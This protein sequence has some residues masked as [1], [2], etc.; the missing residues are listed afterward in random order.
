ME[1]GIRGASNVL[2]S[3]YGNK[4]P[5]LFL[6]E[7]TFTDINLEG[8]FVP[9]KG[10]QQGMNLIA[11]NENAEATFRI[12]TPI[13]SMEFLEITA[14]S[15]LVTKETFIHE[16]QVLQLD[17]DNK[18]KLK[19]SPSNKRPIFVFELNVSGR[20]IT[21]KITEK[22]YVIDGDE[23][24]VTTSLT[25]DWI[26]VY[27]YHKTS[28]QIVEIGKFVNMGYLSLLGET[29]IYNQDSGNTE[30]LKFDFPKIEIRQQFNLQMLNATN[31]DQFFFMDCV[32]LIENPEDK[33]LLR[34]M[35][36]NS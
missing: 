15:E 27:Y 18:A 20:Q 3:K 4:E 31:P 1:F 19:S 13:F 2:L 9:S 26:L 10:G 17:E 22:N 23:I 24:T 16:I 30:F 28:I 34:L 33:V 35:K 12:R 25:G 5:I 29:E 14:G 21:N 6:P 8:E 11:W 36:A 32:A 7:I